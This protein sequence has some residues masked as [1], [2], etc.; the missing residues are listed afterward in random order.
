[1]ITAKQK[2][3]GQSNIT[4]AR[5]TTADKFSQQYGRFEARMK[6]PIQ[7]GAWPAFWLMP[8]NPQKTWPLE[9][10]ID[11][12]EQSGASK[13]EQQRILGAVHFGDKWP[14]NTHYSESILTPTKWGKDFHVYRVDWTPNL[15]R[16]SVDNKV[17]GEVTPPDIKPYHWPFNNMPF[18]IILNL[19]MG[20]TLGGDV[21]ASFKQTQLLVD[22]VRVYSACNHPVEK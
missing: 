1:M 9:G 13:K 21:P 19:A 6:L 14:N 11:I 10:E 7:L 16:W 17:F 22:Y 20:G 3:D 12:L 8:E 4:S 15:I 5:I 2:H 18:H